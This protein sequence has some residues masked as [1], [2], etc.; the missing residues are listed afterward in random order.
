MFHITFGKC[1][2]LTSNDL[3]VI[4][5]YYLA[6]LAAEKGLLPQC[7]TTFKRTNN[8]VSEFIVGLE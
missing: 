4:V 1:Q 2:K 5:L 6:K 7:E 8:Q 3:M